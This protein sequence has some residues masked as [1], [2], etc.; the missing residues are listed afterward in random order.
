MVIK[1]HVK[2]TKNGEVV[3]RFW[4]TLK[5]RTY[6]EKFL[7]FCAPK[8]FPPSSQKVSMVFP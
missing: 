2:K 3:T 8:M 4:Y 7:D 1:D 5:N 6:H